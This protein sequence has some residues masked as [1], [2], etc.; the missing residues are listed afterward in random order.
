MGA[1]YFDL[2][3]MF[4]I[5][6]AF[7]FGACAGSFANVCI[8]RMPLEVSIIT[9]RSQCPLCDTS[10]TWQ[11]NIPLVSWL[12][13][14][15]RCKTCAAPIS[16]RYPI[17][18]MITG[19]VFAL[20]MWRYGIAWATPVYLAVTFSWVVLSGIDWDHQ[21]IPDEINISGMVLGP[22]VAVIAQF[23]PWPTGLILEGI[24]DSAIGLAVG[25]GVIWGIRTLGSAALGQE[26]M[27]FGDV[28]LMAFV[29][30]FLG[31]KLVLIAIFLASIL[32]SVVGIGIKLLCRSGLGNHA[33]ELDPSE[34][35]M[36]LEAGG[37]DEAV[38]GEA[39]ETDE[40]SRYTRI[41]FGP[42]LVLGAFLTMLWGEEL[43]DWYWNG[44][45]CTL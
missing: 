29:G 9:P 5:S 37:D 15:A 39:D 43:W 40:F 20:V 6:V 34:E 18:E 12:T 7:V 31:Y 4:W 25:G 38:G 17:V 45:G 22:L 36:L 26:A 24:I 21:Y 3:P 16:V 13:L 14:G 23:F 28:K 30:S 1:Y 19:T 11:E 41:P 44:L 35:P 32:G 8:Y 27:G 10:L 2:P 33:D 42:Y